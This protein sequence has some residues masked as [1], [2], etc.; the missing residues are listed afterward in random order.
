MQVSKFL[1]NV[2]IIKPKVLLHQVYVTLDEF[3][4]PV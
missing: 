1:N 2:I 4:F 3:D